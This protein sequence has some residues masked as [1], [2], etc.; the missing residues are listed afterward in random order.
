[1]PPDPTPEVRRDIERCLLAYTRGVDRLD[2]D[3]IA[4]AFH[5]DALLEGY[6]SPGEAPVQSFLDRVIP[7]LRDRFRTTQHRLSNITMEQRSD[8]VAV[9]SYVLALHVATSEAGPE[10][11]STF[12]GR[13]IDRFEQRDG[14]WAIAHRQLRVDW[15]SVD[16]IGEQMAGAYVFGTR[17]QSDASYR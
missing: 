12:N 8:H 4:A 6:G 2:A 14:R 9:E 13:Y 11:L 10:Q 16:V 7:S 1:M 3:L 15:S 17:D 5:S